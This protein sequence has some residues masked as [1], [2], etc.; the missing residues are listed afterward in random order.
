MLSYRRPND[1][2]FTATVVYELS[3]HFPSGHDGRGFTGTR[4]SSCGC[5]L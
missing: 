1:F 5:L 3:E 2:I 4:A